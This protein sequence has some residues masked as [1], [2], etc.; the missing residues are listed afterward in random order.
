[1]EP[2]TALTTVIQVI[3][4]IV[5][6]LASFWDWLTGLFGG[7][8]KAERDAKRRVRDAGRDAMRAASAPWPAGLQRP[9]F[10]ARDTS[11][12]V[13]WKTD[14]ANTV[15]DPSQR[16]TWMFARWTE[17][18]KELADENGVLVFVPDPSWGLPHTAYRV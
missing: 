18:A 16:G 13:S 11:K 12:T 5:D 4:A 2:L 15:I 10:S 6:A 9:V 8:T 1:M 14:T 3:P 17:A 7:S